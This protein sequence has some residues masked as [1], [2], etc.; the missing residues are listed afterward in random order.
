MT[1]FEYYA[2]QI[3]ESGYS[4]GMVDGKFVNCEAEYCLKCDFY[5]MYCHANKIKWLYEEH[6]ETPKL[7]PNEKKLCELLR[8]GYLM[9]TTYG[10]LVWSAEEN[11][12]KWRVCTVPL[13][14]CD[15]SF[16]K[17]G[18]EETWRVE[19]LLKLEVAE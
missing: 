9:R 18:E 16:V 6:K 15:F 12:D 17:C 1:N 10:T 7:T 8:E 19:D 11:A 4:F 14:N 5:T 3:K 2:E 13:K